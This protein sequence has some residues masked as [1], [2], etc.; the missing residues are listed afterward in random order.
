MI[1]IFPPNHTHDEF[2]GFDLG[3]AHVLG[4][5]AEGFR[6][7]V[8]SY[9]RFNDADTDEV[10]LKSRVHRV[11]L[12]EHLTEKRESY[13]ADGE[14][15]YRHHGRHRDEYHRKTGIYV[16]RES[17]AH[18]EHHRSA[19]AHADEHHKSVA[20]EVHVRGKP[21]DETSRTEFIDIPERKILYFIEKLF[22]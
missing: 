20:Y 13:R 15:R 12:T 18:H 5:F 10:F 11:E 6:L 14:H 17:Y 16:E 7:V 9:E 1:I 8:L 21:R 2:F 19:E 3:V 4:G 22:P